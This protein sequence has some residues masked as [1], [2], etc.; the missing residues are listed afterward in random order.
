MGAGNGKA[1]NVAEQTSTEYRIHV[2][3]EE[4]YVIV[5]DE[6]QVAIA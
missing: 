4:G 6:T 1:P 5:N 2:P 3:I